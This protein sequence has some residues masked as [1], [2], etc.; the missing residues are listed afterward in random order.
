[1]SCNAFD[2]YRHLREYQLHILKLA[3]PEAQVPTLTP[4][5]PAKAQVEKLREYERSKRAQQIEQQNGRIMDKLVRINRR[6]AE[7]SKS[8]PNLVLPKIRK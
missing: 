2:E 7:V 4:F 6:K 3:N 1:M 8:S 5:K